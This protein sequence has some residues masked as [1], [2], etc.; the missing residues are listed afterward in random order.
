MLLEDRTLPSTFTVL[1]LND[2]GPGS[3]R[4][5]I[6]SGDDTIA[7]ANGLHGTITLTHLDL[8]ADEFLGH[9]EPR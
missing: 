9:P 4:A 1:N 3:L 6:A 2:S 7:F 5:A 8:K